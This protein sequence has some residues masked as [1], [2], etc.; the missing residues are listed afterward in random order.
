M[1]LLCKISCSRNEKKST[2]SRN[3]LQPIENLHAEIINFSYF[4]CKVIQV[5][6]N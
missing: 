6:Q 3:T 5:I 4:T 2:V 1:K